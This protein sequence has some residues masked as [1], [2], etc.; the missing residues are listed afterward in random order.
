MPWLP[1]HL[2]HRLGC[3]DD[4]ETCELVACNLRCAWCCFMC[5]K[6]GKPDYLACK[7]SFEEASTMPVIFVTVE[8]P[9]LDTLVTIYGMLQV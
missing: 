3:S 4:A 7:R 6:M 1:Q 9:W 2:P 5:L 8:D